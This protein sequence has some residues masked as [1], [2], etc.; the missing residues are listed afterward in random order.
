MSHGL[1]AG[2]SVSASGPSLDILA[3]L[4]FR[5]AVCVVR[6]RYRGLEPEEAWEPTAR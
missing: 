6:P 2:S 1:F 5:W 4:L 3:P